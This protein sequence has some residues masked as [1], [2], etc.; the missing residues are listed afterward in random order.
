MIRNTLIVTALFSCLW[1]AIAFSEANFPDSSGRQPL[2]RPAISIDL[3]D[4][5]TREE[6]SSDMQGGW[7]YHETE[8]DA[9][10]DPDIGGYRLSWRSPYI[11]E[12]LEITWVPASNLDVQVFTSVDIEPDTGKYKYH[13]TIVNGKNSF[14]KMS[15]F[16]VE[17]R[18]ESFVGNRPS[19]DW[20]SQQ[21]PIQ[22]W[23]EYYWAWSNTLGGASGITPGDSFSDLYLESD[24]LPDVV[25]CL[26][27]G[28]DPPI[29]CPVELP[30]FVIDKQ[31][32]TSRIDRVSGVTVGPG[33]LH[34][35]VAKVRG[36]I[37][38]SYRQGWLTSE[39]RRDVLLGYIEKLE[40]ADSEDD[41]GTFQSLC[42]ELLESVAAMRSDTSDPLSDEAYGLLHYNVAW[43]RD[44]AWN[45]KTPL[46]PQIKEE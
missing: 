14:L 15:T 30:P 8:A 1:S 32:L 20:R 18:T 35:S 25:T 31:I 44:H 11:G 46:K 39:S 36:H 37:E 23:K 2:A 10:Y 5:D 26:A 6:I 4:H 41:Y 40:V 34:T 29:Y 9:I 45:H 42:N 28:N 38:E 13:Y 19:S 21:F 43:L 33:E 7:I 17:S 22:F 16:A 3:N 24:G 12:L 27:W